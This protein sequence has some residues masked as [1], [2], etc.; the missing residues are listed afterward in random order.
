VLVNDDLR[1]KL[2]RMREPRDKPGRADDPEAQAAFANAEQAALSA[3]A[4]HLGP[5]PDPRLE[6]ADCIPTRR[7]TDPY[8]ELM[9]DVALRLEVG[10]KVSEVVARAWA[11]AQRFEAFRAPVGR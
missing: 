2:A 9:P 10:A 5:D 6:P 4:Q 8:P 11:D 1:R 7:W 3:L